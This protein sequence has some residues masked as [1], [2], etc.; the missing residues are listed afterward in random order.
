MGD[1]IC[2]VSIFPSKVMV[3]K[4]SKKVHFMQFSAGISKKPSSFTFFY[5]YASEISDYIL[6]KNDKV[7]RCRSHPT[8]DISY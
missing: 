7:I 2:L 6:S 5:I 8:W 4:F 3:L 1:H